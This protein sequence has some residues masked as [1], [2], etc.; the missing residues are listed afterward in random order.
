MKKQ[1]LEQLEDISLNRN[2]LKYQ[3]REIN[4]GLLENI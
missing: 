3:L 1:R 2:D 4:D